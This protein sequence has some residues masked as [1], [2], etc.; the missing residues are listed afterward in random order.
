MNT[1]I[2]IFSIVMLI[3]LIVYHF[4]IFIIYGDNRDN[5]IARW[6]QKDDTKSDYTTR[7]VECCMTQLFVS[8][9]T[10]GIFASFPELFFTGFLLSFILPFIYVNPYKVRQIIEAKHM[11]CVEHNGDWRYDGF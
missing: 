10:C 11:F 6:I 9:V 8:F 2:N 5:G 1:V 7:L 3:V 4:A